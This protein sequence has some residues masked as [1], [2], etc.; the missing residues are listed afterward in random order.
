MLSELMNRLLNHLM[1][2]RMWVNVVKG[3]H[4]F[5]SISAIY[6]FVEGYE[7]VI[8]DVRVMVENDE[9]GMIE[10]MFAGV[11]PW[12]YALSRAPEISSDTDTTIALYA[13]RRGIYTA[14]LETGNIYKTIKKEMEA[15][16]ERPIRP[17]Q[18]EA[19]MPP[20]QEH[21]YYSAWSTIVNEDQ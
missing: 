17:A 18:V 3:S 21:S 2:K 20:P 5:N 1:E 6:A 7:D 8:C 16:Q 19:P 9:G 14:H 12:R 10:N 15:H 4:D 11:D 13:K